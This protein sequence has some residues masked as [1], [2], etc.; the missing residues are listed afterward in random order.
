MDCFSFPPIGTEIGERLLQTVPK[1]LLRHF[2]FEVEDGNNVELVHELGLMSLL[3]DSKWFEMI[4][5]LCSVRQVPRLGNGSRFRLL[6]N[7]LIRKVA[8]TL[9]AW[10]DVE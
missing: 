10:Y 5:V 4:L 6:P 3:L 2:L 9:P 8:E 1:S 7:E